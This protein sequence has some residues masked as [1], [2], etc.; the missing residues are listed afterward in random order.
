APSSAPCRTPAPRELWRYKPAETRSG[1]EECAGCAMSWKPEPAPPAA[2][3][4]PARRARYFRSLRSK[5]SSQ[6]VPNTGH[7]GLSGHELRIILTFIASA[8][9]PVLNESDIFCQSLVPVGT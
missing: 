3:L 1:W 4:L 6:T 9:G 8:I 7:T 5:S 2:R